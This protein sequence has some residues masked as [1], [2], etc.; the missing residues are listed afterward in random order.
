MKKFSVTLKIFKYSHL[1][2]IEEKTFEAKDKIDAKWIAKN[3]ISSTEWA[4]DLMPIPDLRTLKTM[5]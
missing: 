2:Y 4:M 1:K 5:H 3:F